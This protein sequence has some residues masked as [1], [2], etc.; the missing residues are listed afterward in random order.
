M[1]IGQDIFEHE[2]EHL[3]VVLDFALLFLRLVSC[4]DHLR[5]TLH[6]TN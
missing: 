1:D 2:V 4:V 3:G 6:R 5:S